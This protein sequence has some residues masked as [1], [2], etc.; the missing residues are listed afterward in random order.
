[1]EAYYGDAHGLRDFLG[2]V[3][4]KYH[5]VFIGYRLEEFELLERI[6]HGSKNNL[7]R[8]VLLH[9]YLNELN[10]FRIQ[11]KYF[12]KL[13]IEPIRYYLDFDGYDRLIIVLSSW[14]QQLI[15]KRGKDYYERIQVIDEVID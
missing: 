11:Q 5:V 12:K 8:Y 3:F 13:G 10:F 15:D 2:K 4:Q 9:T 6:L 1:M 7:K 14:L